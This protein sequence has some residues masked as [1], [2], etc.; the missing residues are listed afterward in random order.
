MS[1]IP[2]AFALAALL[3]IPSCATRRSA[4]EQA[5]RLDRET[6]GAAYRPGDHKPA[7]PVLVAGSMPEEFLRYALLNSPA[8]EAAYYDWFATVEKITE[9]GTPPDPRLTFQMDIQRVVTSL[10]PGLMVD[11][12]G[13]GKLGAA[14]ESATAESRIA[15]YAYE[16]AMLQAALDLKRAAYGLALLDRQ[17]ELNRQM[18]AVLANLEAVA[19]AR[20]ASGQATLQDV[21]RAQIEQERL[22]SMIANLE[23]AR[24]PFLAKFKAAL[25]I[26]PGQPEPPVMT[27]PF[28]STLLNLDTD[29]LLA[30]AL[31]RNPELQGMAAEIR[32]A[33]SGIKQARFTA[34]PDFTA[35]L[36]ADFKMN[37]IL[38][39][40]QASMT[41]PVWR[42]KIAADLAAAQAGKR[43]ATAR[44]TA[45]QIALAVAFADL[46]YQARQ[47]GRNLRLFQDNL[48]PKAR[49]ALE[50]AH[51][52]Y[53]SG[54]VDFQTVQENQRLVLEFGLAA[55]AAREQH[56]SALAELSLVIL[57]RPPPDAPLAK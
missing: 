48:L 1:R 36:E 29:R 47:S 46:S 49:Q 17:L 12:P 27:T 18:L 52:A 55:A 22:K 10:M 9:A 7:L 4:D 50:I 6:V 40:P 21:L 34:V 31:A 41:L 45:G 20:N 5:A 32:L 38:L 16:R 23:D 51:D 54:G 33:E 43:A 3:V 15:Y 19:E 56:D 14:A 8:V 24:A 11:L 57:A 37:P 25:G 39:R 28:P 13:P 35:G 2:Q 42:D 44:L 26:A 30:E 53:R